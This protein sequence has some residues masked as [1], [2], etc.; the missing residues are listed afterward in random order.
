[1]NIRVVTNVF[2]EN[3]EEMSNLR[4]SFKM[5]GIFA[6]LRRTKLKALKTNTELGNLLTNSL[7][8]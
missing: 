5:F 6:V 7:T 3:L 8:L 2:S 4:I 1:V